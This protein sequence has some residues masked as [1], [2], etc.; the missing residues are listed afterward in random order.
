MPYSDR[1][2]SRTVS[3]L[4]E[5]HNTII[6]HCCITPLFLWVDHVNKSSGGV[7]L[8][9]ELPQDLSLKVTLV[10]GHDVLEGISS[11]KAAF[12]ADVAFALAWCRNY[13]FLARI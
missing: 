5:L 8:G 12:S 13:W 10:H 9:S 7:D 3:S 6:D 4:K 1:L 11:F 2:K